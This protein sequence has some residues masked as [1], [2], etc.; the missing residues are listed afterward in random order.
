LFI[1]E[2]TKGSSN[3]AP[4]PV[5]KSKETADAQ[6]I[7]A[8]EAASDFLSRSPTFLSMETNLSQGQPKYL[9]A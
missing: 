1:L 9:T 7:D 5:V 2:R 6:M 3:V 8:P 4:Q